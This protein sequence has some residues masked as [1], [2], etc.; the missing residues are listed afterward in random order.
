MSLVK[1]TAPDAFLTR[2]M[3]HDAAE[4]VHAALTMINIGSYE[5]VIDQCN[6]K[7]IVSLLD[8]TQGDNSSRLIDLIRRYSFDVLFAICIGN[9]PGLL[10]NG[11]DVLKLIRAMEK[12]KTYAMP[13]DAPLRLS[14]RTAQLLRRFG[15]RTS[16][17]RAVLKHL[18]T[19]VGR[20]SGGA[21][22][23]LLEHGTRRQHAIE[24]CMAMVIAGV[25][26][27]ITHLQ[28][29]LFHIYN[30]K[31]LFGQ[32]EQEIMNAKLSQPATIKE[33]VYGRLTMPLLHAVLRESLRLQQPYTNSARLIAP[34][35]GVVV[36]DVLIPE[37]VSCLRSLRASIRQPF[38]F[39]SSSLRA[40]LHTAYSELALVEVNCQF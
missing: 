20:E 26:P 29:I 25:D 39:P 8:L 32:L 13:F 28:T 37:G 30:D 38:L 16:F 24:A 4:S 1:S 10:E 6:S 19:T 9:T 36:I 17:E 33:L 27:L 22:G 14:P 7:F 2:T 31:E 23:W 5:P 40:S 21:L 35:G 3:H 18:N 11:A 15:I 12:W 34:K